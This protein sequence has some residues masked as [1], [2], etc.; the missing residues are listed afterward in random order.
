[1]E[2]N[3]ELLE[4]LAGAGGGWAARSARVAWRGSY[5]PS[6]G[7]GN[8][9]GALRVWVSFGRRGGNRGWN[10]AFGVDSGG[11]ET[12]SHLPLLR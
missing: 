6:F 4:N 9:G 8:G 5:G 7:S 11:A 12:G 10:R 2:D 3:R 1:M